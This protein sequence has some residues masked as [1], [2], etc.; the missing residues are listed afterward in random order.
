[1]IMKEKKRKE[2]GD[3]PVPTVQAFESLPS[4]PAA[5]WQ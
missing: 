1:M 2:S 3:I 4:G 5:G